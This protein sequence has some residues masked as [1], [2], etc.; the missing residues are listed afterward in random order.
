MMTTRQ[1]AFYS[2]REIVALCQPVTLGELLARG[3]DSNDLIYREF[4][5]AHKS[6]AGALVLEWPDGVLVCVVAADP[7]EF[8]QLAP[9][10]K[11]GAYHQRATNKELFYCLD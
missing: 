6:H 5:E 9:G 7:V 4:E 1:Y 2:D 3:V 11:I 10:H 8:E